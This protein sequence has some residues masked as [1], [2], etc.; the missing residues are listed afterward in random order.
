MKVVLYLS[1]HEGHPIRG[2]HKVWRKPLWT[3]SCPQPGDRVTLWADDEG[4]PREGQSWPVRSRCWD[5]DG[6]IHCSLAPMVVDPDEDAVA[7]MRSGRPVREEPYYSEVD[8]R[9]E[10]DL[11]RSGWVSQ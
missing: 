5:V 11:E 1:I 6:E 2:E 7:L 8:G 3:A 9:P 10:P 4:D